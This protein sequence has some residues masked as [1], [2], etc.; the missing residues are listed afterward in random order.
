MVARF[1]A[2]L[3]LS[4]PVLADGR[5]AWVEARDGLQGAYFDKLEPEKR[6][7]W[8]RA[9][10]G[11]DHSEVVTSFG[12][13][14]SRYGTYLDQIES[15][16]VENQVKLETY[17]HRRGLSEEEIGLRNHFTKALEKH[18][19]EFRKAR[20]SEEILIQDLAGFR[21]PKTIQMA[22]TA[23]ERHASS[24]VRALLARACAQWHTVLQDD[25]AS[26]KQKEVLQQL[27][28]AFIVAIMLYVTFGDLGRI[29]GWFN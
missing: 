14:A 29:F 7:A 3:L 9:L 26:A 24:Y 27:G 13:I 11:W 4:L 2:L 17:K 23:F 21:D 1:L 22:L 12:D 16:I 6:D 15:Q 25:K 10:G 20:A 19:A 28:F 8:F 18:E 5:T